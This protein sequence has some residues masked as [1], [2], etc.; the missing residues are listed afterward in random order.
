MT[1]F[2]RSSGMDLSWSDRLES[3]GFSLSSHRSQAPKIGFRSW[4]TSFFGH[5]R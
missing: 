5:H 4:H 3:D 1:S 2:A